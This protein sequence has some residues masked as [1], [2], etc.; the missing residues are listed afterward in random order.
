MT[1]LLL[2]ATGGV[3]G[4]VIAWAITAG[5]C[6]THILTLEVE[7]TLLQDRVAKLEERAS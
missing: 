7:N 3:V 6:A 2:F 4:A 5:R 1:G